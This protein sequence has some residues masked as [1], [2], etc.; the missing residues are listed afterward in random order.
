MGSKQTY[1][2]IKELV[3]DIIRQTKGMV[4]YDTVTKEVKK[5]FPKSRW[6]KTHW[7]WYKYQTR[8][9]KFQGLFSKQVKDNLAKVST[10]LVFK[11]RLPVRLGKEESQ[12]KIDIVKHIGDELLN[13]VRFMINE[14]AKDNSDLRFRINRWVYARLMQDEIREK[15]PVKQELWDSMKKKSCRKCG[16]KFNSLKGVEIHR[17]DSTTGYT[18]KNCELLCRPCHQSRP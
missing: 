18:V 1:K 8:Q 12:K 2:T 11:R 16:K 6:Q 14:F 10:D 17:K 13:H 4:G 5:R 3:F 9:G 7:S 15:R